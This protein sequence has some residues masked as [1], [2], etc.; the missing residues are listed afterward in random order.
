MVAVVS[1]AI[2]PL[3]SCSTSLRCVS[4]INVRTCMPPVLQ[5]TREESSTGQCGGRHEYNPE[6]KFRNHHT[7]RWRRNSNTWTGSSRDRPDARQ[8]DGSRSLS[9]GHM[10]KRPEIGN[11]SWR[12][13]PPKRT[14]CYQQREWQQAHFLRKTI[15]CTF[16]GCENRM[17]IALLLTTDKEAIVKYVACSASH[18]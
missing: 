18:Q 15:P 14:D 2:R 5:K 4:R 13:M 7:E 11:S 8:P 1:A 17:S 6:L 12:S 10:T 16:W 9:A 3:L